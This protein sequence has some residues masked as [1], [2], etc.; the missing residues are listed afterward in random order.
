MM[1]HQKSGQITLFLILVALLSIT[2]VLLYSS[3]SLTIPSSFFHQSE[4]DP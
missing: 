1:S 2:A 4:P 3:G